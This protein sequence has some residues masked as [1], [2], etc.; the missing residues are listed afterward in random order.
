MPCIFW[1][2]QDLRLHDNPA[3]T[4]ACAEGA[5]VPVYILD[6]DSAGARRMGGASR[7]WLH[8]SLAELQRKLPSLLLRHGNVVA[9]LMQIAQQAGATR[10]HANRQYEPWWRQTE[11]EI[12]A[13]MDLVLHHGNQLIDPALLLTGGGGRYKVFTPWWRNLV[14]HM[15]PAKPLPEPDILYTDAGIVTD[16]LD[17]WNLLPKH[18]NWAQHFDGWTPGEQ[19]AR[20][21]SARFSPKLPLIMRVATCHR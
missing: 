9:Q 10:I 1:F 2:R 13:E 21:A 16:T 4:A 14:S 18:P 7:W 17:E 5:V 12:A 11:S 8:H 15:P 6:D 19:G 3:L 20:Q